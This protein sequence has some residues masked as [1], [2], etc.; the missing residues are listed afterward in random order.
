MIS[1]LSQF[2][3][4][5]HPVSLLRLAIARAA[6]ANEKRHHSEP[7]AGSQLPERINAHLCDVL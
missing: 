3:I 5:L 1:D 4:D 6:A 2:V 7:K